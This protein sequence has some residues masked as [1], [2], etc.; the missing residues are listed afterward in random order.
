MKVLITTPKILN[1][2]VRIQVCLHPNLNLRCHWVSHGILGMQDSALHLFVLHVRLVYSMFCDDARIISTDSPKL[3]AVVYLHHSLCR[4][5]EELPFCHW[6]PIG[7]F[8]LHHTHMIIPPW[9]NPAT[10][11]DFQTEQWEAMI[12]SPYRASLCQ[13]WLSLAADILGLSLQCLTGIIHTTAFHL[14]HPSLPVWRN[15][16]GPDRC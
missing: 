4:K 9:S 14:Y 5:G 3:S 12:R 11:P 8:S 1:L 10:L 16:A 2:K 13:L 7:K 6:N 15:V